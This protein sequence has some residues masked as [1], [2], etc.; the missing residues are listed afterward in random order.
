MRNKGRVVYPNYYRKNVVKNTERRYLKE[1]KT[2]EAILNEKRVQ[3]SSEIS[4]Y[5]QLALVC[6]LTEDDEEAK[7]DKIAA[8]NTM[9]D[10]LSKWYVGITN[11]QGIE[12]AKKLL[13]DRVDSILPDSFFAPSK[14]AKDEEE[15]THIRMSAELTSK[16]YCLAL[17]TECGYSRDDLTAILQRAKKLYEIDNSMAKD[18]ETNIKG[19][20]GQQGD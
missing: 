4:K 12:R 3:A 17:H 20:E 9:V 15:L 14:L 8:V 18:E 10:T 1:R 6:Y 7:R 2:K 11:T 13:S 19:E 16:I 5:I